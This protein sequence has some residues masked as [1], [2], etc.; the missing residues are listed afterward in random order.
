M[1]YP[2]TFTGVFELQSNADLLSWYQ[3]HVESALDREIADQIIK[4]VV[5][6]RIVDINIDTYQ[7]ATLWDEWSVKLSGLAEYSI[8]GFVVAV[9][10]SDDVQLEIF[11]AVGAPE[12]PKPVSDESDWFP[13]PGKWKFGAG[14]DDAIWAVEEDGDMFSLRE[15]ETDPFNETLGVRFLKKRGTAIFDADNNDQVWIDC[16]WRVGQAAL[17]Q[18]VEVL[19][20]QKLISEETYSVSGR[21]V[22][23]KRFTVQTRFPSTY[24]PDYHAKRSEDPC[25]QFLIAKGRGI[26][27]LDLFTGELERAEEPK[28]DSPEKRKWWKFW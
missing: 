4:N 25:Y 19:S 27:E 17:V 7:P 12:T 10:V 13:V 8:K 22:P 21:E 20:I 18:G 6:G 5:D 3:D 24:P 14:E 26:V 28:V 1:G 9:F 15:F 11:D 2:Q 16:G 23:A